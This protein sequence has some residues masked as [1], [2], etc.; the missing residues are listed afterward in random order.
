MSYKSVPQEFP[1]SHKSVLQ[2]CP[3]RV[4]CKSVLQECRTRVSHK[5]VPQ[6]CPTRVSHKSVSQE[7]PTRVSHK[8]VPQ[9]CP[10]RVSHKSV[11]QECPTRVSYK[12]D[13]QECA[14]RVSYRVSR[15]SVLQE[16]HLDIL[17]CRT[18]LH[19]GSWVPSCYILFLKSLLDPLAKERVL[20]VFVAP[21]EPHLACELPRR[22]QPRLSAESRQ[23]GARH[24]GRFARCARGLGVNLRGVTKEKGPAESQSLF[25]IFGC[26]GS[27]NWTELKHKVTRHC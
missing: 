5:S 27:F 6:E 11:L 19:S 24:R 13:P 7:C 16:C 26:W 9:E 4:S 10:I 8:S 2:E 12:S 20:S 1:T 25:G 14:T 3:T 23:V 21:A 15:K 17:V 18:C 22:K